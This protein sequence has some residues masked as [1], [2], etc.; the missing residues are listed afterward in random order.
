MENRRK[1]LIIGT[2]GVDL[3]SAVHAQLAKHEVEV[4]SPDEATERGI[5][6]SSPN[7]LAERVNQ[8][9]TEKETVTYFQPPLT[10][11][12]RRAQERKSKNG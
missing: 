1:F 4:V 8:I 9:I 6:I 2:A 12:E 10:R 3:N 11:R 5:T 7:T